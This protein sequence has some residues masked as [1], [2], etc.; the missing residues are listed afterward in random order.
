MQ[1]SDGSVI[2]RSYR[3]GVLEEG[4]NS[5]EAKSEEQWAMV[6]LPTLILRAGQ[7]LVFPHDQ[8]LS[9]TVAA[10]MQRAIKNSRLVNFPTLNHY[11]LLFDVEPEPLE[12]IRT[13]IA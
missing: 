5:D 8:L 12:V 13:F 11:T 3:E 10:T 6:Q 7:E 9:E 4:L 1:Q 2:S